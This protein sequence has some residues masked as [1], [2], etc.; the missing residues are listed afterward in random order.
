MTHCHFVCDKHYGHY[1]NGALGWFSCPQNWAHEASSS[2]ACHGAAPAAWLQYQSIFNTACALSG[3]LQLPALTWNAVTNSLWYGLVAMVNKYWLHASQNIMY[4][5]AW[6]LIL[7]KP[8]LLQLISLTRAGQD[9]IWS[10][11]GLN[12]L[13]QASRQEILFTPLPDS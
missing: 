9:C 6:T 12:K 8:M 2:I 5:A 11:E 10:D 4:D 13:P 3:R 1:E 7:L